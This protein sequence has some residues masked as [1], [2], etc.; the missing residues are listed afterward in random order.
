[1]KIETIKIIE[2]NIHEHHI[3]IIYGADLLKFST[4]VVYHDLYFSAL[5]E[6][7]PESVINKVV[8]HIALFEGMQLCSFFPKYY[9]ISLIVQGLS[10]P[11]LDFFQKMYKGI[12]AQHLYETN[13]SDYFGP[14]LIYPEGSLKEKS[15][16]IISKEDSTVLQ[17]CGGGKDSFIAMKLL[18]E[19]D[20]PFSSVQ[21][22]HT[23]YGKNEYQHQL[24]SKVVEQTTPIRQH[25]ISIYD[26][27]IDNSFLR[28]YS[29]NNSIITF[30]ETPNFIFESLI[31]M[32]YW[33]YNYLS[34][35]HEKSSNTGSL[36]SDE[37]GMEVN[38]Q[39]GKSYEAEK[40]LNQYIREVLFSD[41][42]YFSILQPIYEFRIFKNLAKYPKSLSTIFSC[43]NQKPWCKKCS[44]CAYVWMSWMAYFNQE[45][46]ESVFKS[47]LFDDEELLPFYKQMW[48]LSE[49]TPFECVG[50]VD[51]NRLMMKKCWDKGVS[52]KA[53]DIFTKE[54]L[55]D[56]SINWHKIE[57]KYDYVYGEEHSIPNWIFGKIK[58]NL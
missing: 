55:S 13:V 16:T 47:N 41:F 24:I 52:G 58:D 22:S 36:F 43:N 35:A 54:V 46:V 3:E 8:C 34:F 50:E 32:L 2:L 42:T 18:Q 19:A 23:V 15:P 17:T 53:M 49:Y 38:H 27:F 1:M 21:F 12:F 48:G 33:K 51:E 30:P 11:V 44:K 37:L 14:E 28:L 56:S 40:Y 4:K 5:K 29:P 7:Y 10:R 9:D 6:K 45:S 39:W 26:D 20:I 25:K 57:Q 31:L